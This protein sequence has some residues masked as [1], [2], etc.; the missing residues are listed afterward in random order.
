[1]KKSL[2]ACLVVGLICISVVLASCGS[3]TSTVTAT[4]TSTVTATITGPAPTPTT[5]ST[6]TATPKYGGT[7]KV[8]GP[9]DPGGPFGW[10]PNIKGPASA[11]SQ[12][13]LESLL[14]QSVD[15]SFYPWLASSYELASDKLSI[16]F[17]L[18][19]GVQFTDG[20]TFN[21]EAVKF[22]W[23]A[24]IAANNEPFW[25]SV[26]VVSE[27]TVK[28]NLTSWSNVI[29]GTFGD[30]APIASPTAFQQNGEDWSNY[31]PVGTGPFILESYQQ[32][33]RST[34]TRNP[35]YW[36]TDEQG[37]QMPYLDEIWIEYIT[38]PLTMQAAM[39]AGELDMMNVTLGKQAYD[40][41][42]LGFTTIMVTGTN[43]MLVP[44]ASNPDSPFA[45]LEVRLAVSHAIDRE[46]IA[47]GLGYGQMVAPYQ[48]PPRTNA[49]YDTCYIGGHRYD[50]DLARQLLA[51]AGYPTGFSTAIYAQPA[52]RQD[53]CNA[54]LQANLN[55]VG[56]ITE[57]KNVDQ[58]TFAN[59]QSTG[60]TD[61]MLIGPF[62][63]FANFNA[64][65]QFYFGPTSTQEVSWGATPKFLELYNASLASDEPD[66][67]LI[68]AVTD[69]MVDNALVIP[70]YESGLGFCWASYVI[71]GG[72]GDRGLATNWNM[73]AVWLDK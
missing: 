29:L 27:Y 30:A 3:T 53:D 28:L 14:R 1:M 4:K 2:L 25:D 5:T 64:A 57:I 49:A 24:Q 7:M 23:D 17:H 11:T 36:K 35:N 16:T 54:V 32:D 59:L 42:N 31:N 13:V 10:P 21:A 40:M 61:S 62:A 56:I 22:N 39:Q 72:F 9:P 70:V 41:E 12:P 6:P 20:T 48:L 34:Y 52:A 33:T 69:Y 50:P 8:A 66:V 58:G 46:G 67:D 37:N 43:Y 60:W 45:S 38:D 26:E 18:E 47:S 73:E 71:N 65:L 68:R 55:A 44:D 51:D 15:G 63:G 19:E